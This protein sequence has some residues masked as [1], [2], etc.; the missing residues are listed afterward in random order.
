MK[1]SNRDSGS[2]LILIIG[3][4]AALAI[5]AAMTVTLLGNVMANT[6]RDRAQKTSFSVSEAAIDAAIAQLSD[7]WPTADAT[8]DSTYL[9]PYLDG[10]SAAGYATP[11]PPVVHFNDDSGAG[12]SL[13]TDAWDKNGDLRIWVEAAATTGKRTS[14]VRVL[15]ER[16][17]VNLGLLDNVAVWTPGWFN[18]QSGTSLASDAVSF[19][20][21][22][23]GATRAIVE[24]NTLAS[25]SKP[26]DL[27]TVW[28]ISPATDANL[29]ISPE[30]L[31]YFR[32]EA[33]RVK[34]AGEAKLYTSLPNGTN[35]TGLVYLD[36]GAASDSR[37]LSSQNVNLFS[38]GGAA[39]LNGDGVGSNAK[40]GVLIV[41]ATELQ[42]VGNGDYYGLI[43]CSG[44]IRIPSGLH[45][46]G[47]VLAGAINVPA[48]TN[49]VTLLGSQSVIYNN[50]VRANLDNQ[51]S[52]SV[53]MVANTWRELGS[54]PA[55]AP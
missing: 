49:A 39:V 31:G 26:L 38:G 46:H 43:Y 54:T 36:S 3:V 1:T 18:S 21:L 51:Y 4:I 20:I 40:P 5:L 41:D 42:L 16:V 7:A 23:P 2:A 15:V 27:S 8:F 47:M 13:G 34:T 32:A 44:A 52:I 24:Y 48:G 29:L 28:P 19:E 22:G 11:P 37:Q 55:P 45:I 17:M 33:E 14:R 10:L 9:Q 53:H 12:G 25:D 50:N 6:S 30:L 35:F